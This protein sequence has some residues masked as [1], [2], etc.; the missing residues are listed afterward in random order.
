M[1]HKIYIQPDVTRMIIDPNKS[2][3]GRVWPENKRNL[4]EP[5]A[6]RQEETYSHVDCPQV[7]RI[8][9]LTASGNKCESNQ[10][11]PK[12]VQGILNTRRLVGIHD[13]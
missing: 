10:N 5:A 1:K 9:D 4:H 12:F 8:V 3:I 2:R 7:V 6:L 11:G 13:E